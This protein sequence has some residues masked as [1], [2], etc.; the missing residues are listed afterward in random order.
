MPKFVRRTILGNIPTNEYYN[1]NIYCGKYPYNTPYIRDCTLYAITRSAEIAEEQITAYD[2]YSNRSDVRMPMFTRNGYGDAIEWWNDTLWNKTIKHSEAKL[3]DII[4]YGTGW[5]YSASKN[6][7]YGHVRV[8]EAMDDNYFYC[9]GG[10]EDN[11][12][13]YKFNIKVPRSD[14]SGDA[15]SGLVG[16][17]HNP[18]I[19]DTEEV[20]YKALYE[21]EH[22]KV[23]KIK[24]IVG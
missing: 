5:G 21:A 16:F 18:Y 23:L 20:D 15:L 7:Y 11:K 3:G 12:G 1:K 19:T 13:T 24:E 4:V 8:I 6:K 2:K 14:G 17:I 10:N 22:E 9:S